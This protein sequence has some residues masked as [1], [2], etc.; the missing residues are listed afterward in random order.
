M[1]FFTV[2]FTTVDYDHCGIDL[3]LE[4]RQIAEEYVDRNYIQ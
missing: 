3:M 2:I 4:D 1:I